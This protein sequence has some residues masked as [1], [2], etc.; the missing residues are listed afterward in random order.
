MKNI[1]YYIA[2]FICASSLTAQNRVKEEDFAL[3][4]ALRE[5]LLNGYKMVAMA[6]FFEKQVK[7]YTKKLNKPD[8]VYLLYECENKAIWYISIERHQKATLGF[9]VRPVATGLEFYIIDEKKLKLNDEF[10]LLLKQIR[11]I[12]NMGNKEGKLNQDSS[13]R[14]RIY[15]SNAG[16]PIEKMLFG[17]FMFV[18]SSPIGRVLAA[19]DVD[20]TRNK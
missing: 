16:T 4:P 12:I 1:F 7:D 2:T 11:E 20:K 17:D 9:V 14:L 3:T 15:A 10:D 19:P 8:C 6:G 18:P 13:C 5:N